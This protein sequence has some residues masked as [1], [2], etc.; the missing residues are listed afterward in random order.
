MLIRPILQRLESGGEAHDDSDDQRQ[1]HGPH[2]HF[3][4]LGLDL[5]KVVGEVGE[6]GEEAPRQPETGSEAQHRSD[7]REQNPVDA[8][9][10]SHFVAFQPR[11]LEQGELLAP[12]IY[13][14]RNR[15][16][17]QKGGDQHAHDRERPDAEI[18]GSEGAVGELTPGSRAPHGREAVHGLGESGSDFF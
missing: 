7:R 11:G 12:S 18:D 15:A 3:E 10:A 17:G 8:H 5:L 13:G 2:R 6:E 4:P 16:V 9:Q 1:Q 14:E